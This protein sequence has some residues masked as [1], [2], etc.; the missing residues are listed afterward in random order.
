MKVDVPGG[1]DRES[2]I[3]SF[4]IFYGSVRCVNVF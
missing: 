4:S 3:E 1:E 2:F